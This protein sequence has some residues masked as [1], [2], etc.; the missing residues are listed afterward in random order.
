MF[1]SKKTLICINIINNNYCN[2]GN[3]CLYA[4]NLNEQ[5]INKKRQK[6]EKNKIRITQ[7]N[8]VL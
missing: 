4:H 5:N 3:N 6:T 2:F 7:V 1:G 8:F